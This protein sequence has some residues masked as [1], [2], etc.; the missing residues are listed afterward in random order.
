M[1]LMFSFYGL[2]I[3][4]NMLIDALWSAVMIINTSCVY[5]IFLLVH[6]FMWTDERL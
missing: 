4:T 6:T 2:E 5:S 3:C 1:I